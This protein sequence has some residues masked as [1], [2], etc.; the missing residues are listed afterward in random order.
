MPYATN[1]PIGEILD[2]LRTQFK[3]SETLI[4]EAPPGA[5][6][7]TIIPLALLNEDW[8]QGRRIILLQPRR[9]ATRN[10]AARMASLLNENVGEQVGYRM[11]QEA[12]VSGATRIEVVTEGI[13]LRM[14]QDDPTLGDVGLLIFDEFHERS[15][16]ADLGLALAL[17]ARDTFGGEAPFR[18]LVMSATLQGIPL[19]ALLEA[20]V[21][22]SEG[23]SY[24]VDVIYGQ[25]SAPRER[26]TDRIIAT[27]VQALKNHPK[28]SCLV[29]LP[30]EAE[31]RRTAAALSPPSD[32]SVHELYGNLS[33]DA[34]QQ[35]IA[36]SETGQRKVVLATNIAETSLTIDGVDVVIDA[37]LERV[38]VYDPNTGMTRL[39]TVR[40]S[41]ASSEQR[42]GRAGRMRAGCCYRLWSEN[43]QA[44]LEQ[45]PLPEIANA[46]LSTLA[47]QLHTWGTPNPAELR[48]LTPPPP[49]AFDQAQSLLTDLGA[50]S[51]TPD[52]PQLTEHGRRMAELS[53]HPRLAHMLLCGQRIGATE[54]ASLL[55]AAL[56]ERD[57]LQ[58]DGPEMLDR[59]EIL[60]SP[61]PAPSP[62]RGWKQRCTRLAEQFRRQLP[63]QSIA[64]L[65]GVGGEQILAY[66]LACAYPDRIARKRHSG[67]YQLANGR[68]AQFDKPCALGKEKWLAIAEVSGRTGNS[69]DLIRSATGLDAALF[70]SVLSEVIREVTRVDWDKKTGT[71]IAEKQRRC[72]A[73]LLGRQRLDRVPDED[74]V[75]GLLQLLQQS[76]LKQLTWD[77]YSLRF[78]QRNRMMQKLVEDWPDFSDGGLITSAREWLAPYLSSVKR[79]GDLKKLKLNDI[80]AAR[81]TWEQRQQLGAWLPERIEVPSGSKIAIDYAQDKPV[82]AV[83]LQEMFGCLES[84]R[85]ANGRMA[86]TVHLLSPA[87]RPLQ[88]T[89][90]LAGFWSSSYQEVKKEMRGR[91]PKHPWP[92][93]PLTAT[94]TRHTKRKQNAS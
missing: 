66:L 18:I 41:Q 44:Q 24:P 33:L 78:A 70:D 61:N 74:R 13:L 87:G 48:W 43:Q 82:L 23:R 55:A 15:L 83:K 34:Q 50:L 73:L 16:D 31:I 80:L 53:L 7:T 92:D 79:L 69:S 40:I 64:V 32:V 51:T 56:T 60:Q 67:G 94:A 52:G 77:A 63:R 84:P 30:G 89:E 21:L 19:E 90:D 11:R 14:L 12:R 75:E 28:S 25:P 45:Q 10:A 58:R 68:S 76:Q 35:A 47:L 65:S 42:R 2:E 27:I 29:F 6:K 72:G 20:P 49:G 4:V 22:R 88:I 62:L 91:Y 8:L 59:L 5:G 57:P 46:D 81:L 38:P 36:P 86:V 9:I 93:D 71:F 17:S 37:G 54:T 3:H 39:H 26:I 1:L 85:L